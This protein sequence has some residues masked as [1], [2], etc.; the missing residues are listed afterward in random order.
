MD[1]CQVWADGKV[2]KTLAQP[3]IE[4]TLRP[5]KKASGAP[6][7]ISLMEVLFKFASGVIQE[8]VRKRNPF[9]GLGWNQYGGTAT[10]PETLLLVGQGVVVLRP[11]LALVSLD[12]ENAFGTMKRSYMLEGS[13][14]WCPEICRFLCNIWDHDNI[15]IGSE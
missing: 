3:F 15:S 6:R 5:R 7:N 1:W 14:K 9:E 13:A 11:D 4:Q 12:A 8:Q 10:G 2:P